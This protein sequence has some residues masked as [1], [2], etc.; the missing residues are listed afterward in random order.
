MTI[1]IEGCMH[2]YFYVFKQKGSWKLWVDLIRRQEPE[3]NQYGV[4]VTTIDSARYTHLVDM[5]IKVRNFHWISI[6]DFL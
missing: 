2:D 5:H 6:W 4:Y 3:A 1:P